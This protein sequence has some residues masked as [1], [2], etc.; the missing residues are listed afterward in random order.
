MLGVVG[1]DDLQPGARRCA[2]RPL[3]RLDDDALEIPS[4]RGPE[5]LDGTTSLVIG[6]GYAGPVADQFPQSSFTLDQRQL[7]QIFAIEPDEIEGVKTYVLLAPH[8]IQELAATRRIEA[9]ELPVE[10]R[11]L[12]RQFSQQCA[13]PDERP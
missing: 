13:E 10:N 6:I 5:Y 3:G 9:H 7:A 2:V 4:T 8:Q 1:I 11:V 12:H